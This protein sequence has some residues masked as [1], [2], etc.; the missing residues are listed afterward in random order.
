MSLSQ[1]GTFFRQLS[2]AINIPITLRMRLVGKKQATLNNV[3]EWFKT[4]YN[5]Y[6]LFIKK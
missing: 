3:T 6:Y 2:Q 1:L 5:W 4:V